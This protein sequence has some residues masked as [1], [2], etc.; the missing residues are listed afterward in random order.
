LQ[1]ISAN[2]GDVLL[3]VTF[4][5]RCT[6]VVHDL[7]S[8]EP[9]SKVELS[10]RSITLHKP[11]WTRI[12]WSRSVKQPWLYHGRLWLVNQARPMGQLQW[13]QSH[14]MLTKQSSTDWQ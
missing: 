4:T 6:N 5:A 3:S 13:H 1:C 8:A 2:K 11:S 14:A 7:G 12:S 10:S 9:R